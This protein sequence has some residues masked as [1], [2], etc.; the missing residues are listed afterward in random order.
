MPNWIN[1]HQEIDMSINTREE[2][3]IDID[4]LNQYQRFTYNMI[5]KYNNEK[6]QL[7]MILLGKKKE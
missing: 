4:K 3:D 2:D 7:L 1:R 5:N 6:K